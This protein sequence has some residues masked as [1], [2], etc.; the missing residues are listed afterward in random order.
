MNLE[1]IYLGTLDENKRMIKLAE[2]LGFVREGI[3]RR[4]LFKNGK[5]HDI[6]EFGLLKIEY[7]GEKGNE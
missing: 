3:R 4:S 6:V 1:R 5:Y 2:R 7:E